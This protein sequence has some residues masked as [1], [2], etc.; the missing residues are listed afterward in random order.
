MLTAFRTSKD[1]RAGEIRLPRSRYDMDVFFTAWLH[2]RSS[3]INGR[4]LSQ[5]V[6]IALAKP[7]VHPSLCEILFD[8]SLLESSRKVPRSDLEKICE[9]MSDR[10]G[11]WTHMADDL[12]QEQGVLE[13]ADACVEVA[14]D[15]AWNEILKVRPRLRQQMI[16]GGGDA[17][18]IDLEM[19]YTNE[20]VS[21]ASSTADADESDCETVVSEG[22][23][24]SE[25]V[26][27]SE[28]EVKMDVRTQFEDSEQECKNSMWWGVEGIGVLDAISSVGIG[29]G[30]IWGRRAYRVNELERL[31]IPM[32]R[33]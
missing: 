21:E 11:V 12:A 20:D 19:G 3:G 29:N 23:R 8:G 18:G 27:D 33:R 13:F 14:E 32:A 30:G 7:H 10:T 22:E 2:C 28:E 25:G 4:N 24:L 16:F 1:A 6:T 26:R 31:E 15:I 17:D 9:Y 5:H